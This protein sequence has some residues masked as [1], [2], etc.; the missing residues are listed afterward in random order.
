MGVT[1]LMLAV[2][3]SQYAA[4]EIINFLSDKCTHIDINFTDVNSLSV[5]HH[6]IGGNYEDEE[7]VKAIYP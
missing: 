2:E 5:L 4:V 6:N 3:L 7:I 1:P